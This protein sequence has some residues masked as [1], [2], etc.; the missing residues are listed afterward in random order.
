MDKVKIVAYQWY[1]I[2]TSGSESSIK[3]TILEKAAKK[4]IAHCFEEII[5][6]GIQVV[7]MKRGKA[8]NVNK[9]TMPGYILIKMDMIDQV[10]DFMQKVVKLNRFPGNE[11]K[12]VQVTEKEVQEMMVQLENKAQDPSF[13]EKYQIGEEVRVNDGPFET[14]V[15]RIEEVDYAKKILKLSISIFQRSTELTVDFSQVEKLKND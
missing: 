6:P 15:G 9:K 2:R 1:I 7:K 13:L 8:I 14:F 5:I 10:K 12:I 11:S 3:Q 4:G